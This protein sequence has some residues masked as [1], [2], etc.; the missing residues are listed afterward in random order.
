MLRVCVV[1]P[2]G[3]ISELGVE[4]TLETFQQLVGGYIEGITREGFFAYCDE[5]GRLKN[6]AV[7]TV[8]SSILGV[9]VYGSVVFMGPPD[10][11]GNETD[12]PDVFI[13][14]IKEAA[15]A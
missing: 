10:A 9:D 5:E 11:E 13:Q 12:V 7:N 15:L 3:L 14:E 4:P 8:A 6:R 2:E 1:S